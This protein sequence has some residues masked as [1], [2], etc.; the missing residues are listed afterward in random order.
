MKILIDMSLTPRW[1]PVLEGAGHEVRHWSEVGR[2]DAPDSVL[3]DWARLNGFIV[4][5]NDLDFGTILFSSQATSPSV[6]QLRCDD[7]RPS[8]TALLVLNALDET[9]DKLMQGALVTVQVARH[10]VSVLPLEH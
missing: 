5:T 1:R 6:L 7:V 8:G 9:K 2:E 10:R 4:F 3:M